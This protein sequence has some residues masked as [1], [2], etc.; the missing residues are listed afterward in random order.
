MARNLTSHVCEEEGCSERTQ[1]RKS[2]P[3]VPLKYCPTH[4]AASRQ[5]MKQIFAAGK[6]EREAR[7]Q[8]FRVVLDT[9]MLAGTEALDATNPLTSQRAATLVLGPK[10]HRFVNYLRRIN[11]GDDSAHEYLV[12]FPALPGSID[13]ATAVA[14]TLKP[15]TMSGETLQG[16]R[17]AVR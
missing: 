12:R 6:D 2:D 13:Q 17:I 14:E 11:I 8:V 4:T 15:L 10:N 7:D 1:G 16:L 5:R 3:K 9:A